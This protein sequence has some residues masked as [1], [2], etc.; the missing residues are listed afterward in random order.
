MKKISLFILVIISIFVFT[1]CGCSKK[2][3]TETKVKRETTK[4]ETKKEEKKVNFKD[5]I[6]KDQEF[7]GFKTNNTSLIY[8]GK[9][10]TF[11]T[12][13][14]NLSGVPQA[15]RYFNII[16]KD[17][18]N[19]ELITMHGVI[20]GVVDVNETKII[21]SSTDINITNEANYLEYS[22]VK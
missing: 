6:V 2:E 13:I 14:T 10:T 1:G 17:K 11:R 8:D 12:E 19:R 5:D 20:S 15:V 9:A 7:E 16:V 22:V 18:Y 4:T 3:A 21:T